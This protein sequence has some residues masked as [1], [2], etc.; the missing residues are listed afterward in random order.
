MEQSF[1]E[2]KVRKSGKQVI[3]ILLADE[4]DIL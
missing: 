4:R 3:Y 1:K 2:Q